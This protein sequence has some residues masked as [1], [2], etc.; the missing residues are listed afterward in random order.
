MP[1]GAV[2]YKLELLCQLLK[3]RFEAKVLFGD[4]PCFL[5]CRQNVANSCAPLL[6][7]CRVVAYTGWAGAMARVKKYPLP[8]T[9]AQEYVC[10][11]PRCLTLETLWFR[12][13]SLV[14]TIRFSQGEDGCS[15]SGR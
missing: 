13:G 9:G 15:P 1:S 7:C 2:R 12:E 10:Q 8:P 5:V 6:H 4:I 14:P 3:P 11:C